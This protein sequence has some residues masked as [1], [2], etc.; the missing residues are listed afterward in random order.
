MIKLKNINFEP[1]KINF[2]ERVEDK[3]GNITYYIHYRRKASIQKIEV[4]LNTDYLQGG[5]SKFF[6]DHDFARL[7]NYWINIKNIVFVE[8][9]VIPKK[10]S[11]D[12]DIKL[13]FYFPDGLY[14]E[15]TTPESRWRI[16]KGR[17]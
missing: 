11:S 15:I 6:K 5:E 17:L 7:Q 1:K 16:W 2:L 14:I 12:R 10:H 8:E 4:P 13:L 3:E 9:T